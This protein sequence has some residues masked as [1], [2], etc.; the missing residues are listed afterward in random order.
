MEGKGY[1]TNLMNRGNNSLYWGDLSSYMVDDVMSCL[2]SITWR[3]SYV[4]PK[5]K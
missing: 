3:G 4:L 2:W 5:S 1:F